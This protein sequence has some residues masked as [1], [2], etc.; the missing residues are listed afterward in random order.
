MWMWS[1]VTTAEIKL[2]M[3]RRID[4]EGEIH[5]FNIDKYRCPDF[6]RKTEGVD[7][8]S[9]E[10]CDRIYPNDD[11]SILAHHEEVYFCNKIMNEPK[12]KI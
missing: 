8:G 12:E 2:I 11:S 3:I 5:F 10:Y 9:C 1:F 7:C 6:Q 4:F